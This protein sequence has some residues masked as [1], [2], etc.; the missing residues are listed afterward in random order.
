[1]NDQSGTEK[2]GGWLPETGFIR[3]R[4]LIGTPGKAGK[5]GRLGIVLILTHDAVADD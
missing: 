1:M 3:Q 2:K 4:E 5:P